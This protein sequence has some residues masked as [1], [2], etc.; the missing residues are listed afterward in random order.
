MQ[1]GEANEKGAGD[2]KDLSIGKVMQL[3]TSFLNEAVE[4]YPRAEELLVDN[5]T[6]EFFLQGSLP[7]DFKNLEDTLRVTN[8]NLVF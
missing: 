7:Y 5:Y 4:V 6:P 3:I 1:P 2:L 8:A